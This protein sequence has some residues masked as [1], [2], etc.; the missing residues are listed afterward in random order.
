MQKKIALGLLLIVALPIALLGWFGLRTAEHEQAAIAH[1][2][3]ALAMAQLQ[4][5]NEKIQ[6]LFLER[7][8]L[9]LQH[10]SLV[11]MNEGV[12]TP[13]PVS[14]IR[15]YVRDSLYVQQV[16]LMDADGKRRF[17]DEPLNQ[18]ERAMLQRTA[19][20]WENPQRLL[21]GAPIQIA[22]DPDSAAKSADAAPHR[23]GWYSWYRDSELHHLF[24]VR[25]EGERILGF[26]L[27]PIRLTSDII[28]ALPASG[29]AR[30]ARDALGDA[31]IRLRDANGATVYQWGAYEPGEQ[32]TSAAM[33]P[34]SPPLASWKLE[35]YRPASSGI[36]QGSRL[37]LLASMLAVAL[38]LIGLGYYLYREQS[39][40]MRL[41]AQRV[42]F[43]NQVSH[44][45]KTPLTNIRLY[46]ELLESELADAGQKARK[47][48][49]VINVE[50][51]RLSRLITN[52][53]SFARAQRNRL[54]LQTKPGVVDDTL[55]R[56]LEVFQPALAMRHVTID[57]QA[58]ANA[59]VMLDE[60]AL[61]QILN[62]L[63][64]NVEKYGVSGGK[65]EI[66]SRQDGERTRITLRDYGPG[67]PP[68]ERD[69]IF[70]PFYRA[71]SKL[72]DGVAG[73]GIGL[74]IARDLA[75]LHGG[76]VQLLPVEPGACFEV[77][78]ATPPAP[79]TA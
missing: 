19:A 12:P 78:L 71:S 58:Q 49:D 35:Y 33:L 25:S 4:A 62:N 53:L 18:A 27:D 76:D 68:A 2:L 64:S 24:W 51:M 41:A 30:D 63:L 1:Q 52:V 65:L 23:F 34:L 79:E 54:Q 72:T 45:L 66:H 46:A 50:S 73:T 26:E 22:P 3:Q 16:L 59:R 14:D 74:G 7:Q 9:L 39:R 77:I 55:R 67:I 56:C 5:V 32:E 60:E 21:Q 17:P 28:A 15:D 10:S 11:R 43:V 75:R 29:D 42:N 70:Q 61:E 47:Y 44:E 57:W 20:I 48:I 36:G 8:N 6:R 37:A 69:R 13:R 31:R 40:E 38:V